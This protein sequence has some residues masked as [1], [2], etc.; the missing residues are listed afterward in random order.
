MDYEKKYNEAFEAAKK[1]LGADRKEWKVVQQVLHNIF[2]QLRESEDE[3]IRKAIIEL[4]KEVEE[5]E[6]YTGRQHIPDMLAYLEKKKKKKSLNL[7]AALEWLRKNVRNY[8][9]SEYNEFHKCVEYDGSIDKERLIN[10]FEEAMQK[11]QKPNLYTGT[12]F[13][14]NGHHWGMCARDGGVEI[15]V[16]GKIRDRVSLESET[17]S[18]EWSEEDEKTINEFCNIIVSNAKN[19]YLG[20]YYAPDLVKKLKSLRPHPK[21]EWSEED[22]KK[23]GRLRSVVNQLASYTDSLDVN[24]DYCEGD[25]AELDAWLKA[26]LS[27]LKK[28]NED[29]AK[30]CSN[31][32]SEEDKTNL[33]N[34]IW[35]CENCEKGIE[36]VWIPSQATQIKNLIKSLRPVKQEWSEDDK[37]M[38]TH[39]N[40]YL[41]GFS[42]SENAIK[43]MADWFYE[44]PN[45]FNLQPKQ[46]WSKEDENKMK[47]SSEIPNDIEDAAEDFG[48]RQ[49]LELRPF[50]NKFFIAGA[51]W[52]RE[53]MMKEAVE[54]EIAKDN[55]G[56]NVLRVGLLNN[57][58]EIGDKIRVIISPKED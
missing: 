4:L 26:L 27:N 8:V 46:E 3:R 57:G 6:T 51:K 48:K 10:D 42:C 43:Q 14:Y 17:K 52:D 33:N 24:G 45:R 9:N 35:L 11:E 5:D 28:K 30:L 37:N 53:Q 49:G 39:L 38:W 29:V 34:I 7:S 47:G 12:G 40:G 25:Y 32:L 55:R 54:G 50:A 13:D 1:E 56:N 41:N 18:A 20:R 44:L 21:P 58:F 31:E 22:E 16:D 15:I 2:P 23:I 36:N 19:G